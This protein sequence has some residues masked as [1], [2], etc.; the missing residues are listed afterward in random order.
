VQVLIALL[1]EGCESVYTL[2]DGDKL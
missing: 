1:K 2:V